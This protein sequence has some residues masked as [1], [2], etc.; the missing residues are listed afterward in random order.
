MKTID[1]DHWDFSGQGNNIE[2]MLQK[3]ELDIWNAALPF[4]DKRDDAGHA[5]IVTYFAL[6]LNDYLVGRREIIVPAAILH[7]TGWSQMSKE[8]VEQFYLP[9][10]KD[11][12]QKLRQRH[13][14]EGVKMARSLL[15]D[16]KYPLD[17]IDDIAE[18]ISQHDTRREF[19][20]R[21]DGLVRDADKLWR[22]TLPHLELMLA[23]RDTDAEKAYD[24]DLA[25]IIEPGFF[26]S[27]FSKK[28]ARSEME[29]AYNVWLRKHE[30]K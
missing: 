22:Y 7:D 24:H 5:E 27:E 11:Y 23:K 2:S 12:E 30:T 28:I 16:S 9:N 3:I 25:R 17:Y 14:E 20:S 8:E 4:Q 10:W 1:Y 18:I 13:Q 6:K 29:H 19:F 15:A 21:E 26:Y